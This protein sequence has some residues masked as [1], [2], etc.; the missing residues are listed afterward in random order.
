ML[1]VKLLNKDGAAPKKNWAMLPLPLKSQNI[2]S[3]FLANK[4]TF[5]SVQASIENQGQHNF[6]SEFQKSIRKC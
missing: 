5:D 3:I 6:R 2:L 4:Q 1:L